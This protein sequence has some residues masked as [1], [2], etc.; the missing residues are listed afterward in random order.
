[1]SPSTED[2]ASP[3]AAQWTNCGSSPTEARKRGCKFDILSFAWQLPECYDDKIMEDFLAEKEWEFF[4]FPNK[5]SPVTKETALTGEH[6]LFVT[7]EYHRVHCMYMW[8]QMHRAFTVRKYID[9]HLND[10]H[11]TLHCHKVMLGEQLPPESIG[12]AGQVKYPE[13]SPAL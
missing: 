13:C 1:M 5:T 11:H 4:K 6:T 12:A 2:A 3:Y 7:T 8:R 9:S 10:W